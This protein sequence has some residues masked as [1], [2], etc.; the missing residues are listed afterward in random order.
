MGRGWLAA[1]PAL[2]VWKLKTRNAEMRRLYLKQVGEYWY[3]E[4]QQV[5]L[6][7]GEKK[8]KR[9]T[10][11]LGVK[12]RDKKKL[13]QRRL[14]EL[15][16]SMSKKTEHRITPYFSRYIVEYL[17]QAKI[18][19]KE[20]THQTYTFQLNTVLGLL[21]DLPLS[22]YKPMH[23]EDLKVLLSKKHT[24]RSVNTIL[25]CTGTLFNHAVK[26]EVISQSPMRHTKFASVPK[27][28]MRPVWDREQF[29][30]YMDGAPDRL[31]IPA[32]FGF[33]CGLRVSEIAV[34]DW[35]DVFDGFLIVRSSDEHRTKSDQPRT[36]PVPPVFWS[37]IAKGKG[38]VTTPCAYHHS[39]QFKKRVMKIGLPFIGFHG[40]RHSYAT[41]L[42]KSGIPLAHL[43]RILG[44]A[45]IQTT[46]IYSHVTQD[47]AM[48]LARMVTW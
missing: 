2:M 47:S 33:F 46:M 37:Y 16:I 28:A 3:A 5:V 36:V 41:H 6:I 12:G 15:E 42:A 18:H 21:P 24:P 38:K 8:I 31:R 30:R 48:E 39:A 29:D 19:V 35:S 44:H 10:I 4:K 25:T 34:L 1:A 23:F 26:M 9:K 40:L 32:A 22:D 45:S 20:S 14:R 17:E 43:Q 27:V 11:P 7:E 13:A